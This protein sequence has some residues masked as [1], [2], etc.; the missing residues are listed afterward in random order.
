MEM[1]SKLLFREELET[2]R[3]LRNQAL[4][5]TARNE[6]LRGIERMLIEGERQLVEAEWQDLHKAP[7]ETLG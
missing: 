5:F 6:A 7:A 4:T 3:R 2:L 1:E